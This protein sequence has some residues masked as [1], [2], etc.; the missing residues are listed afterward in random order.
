MGRMLEE[1]FSL[2]NSATKY[3]CIVGHDIQISNYLYFLGLDIHKIPSIPTGSRLSTLFWNELNTVVIYLNQQ[4]V[5][6]MTLEEW[7]F[8]V[9]QAVHAKGRDELCDSEYRC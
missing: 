6:E 7:K 8:K 3:F 5:L 2:T 1:V 4:I 9:G